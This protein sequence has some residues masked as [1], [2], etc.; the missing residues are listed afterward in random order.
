MI[1]LVFLQSNKA[2]KLIFPKTLIKVFLWE[3]W[4]YNK[5][6]LREEEMLNIIQY[7]ICKEKELILTWLV[8]F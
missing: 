5:R 1:T 2:L 7:S 8:F 3:I 6:L 4:R